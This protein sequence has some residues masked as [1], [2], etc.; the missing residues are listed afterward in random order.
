MN[1]PEGS[2]EKPIEVASDR[3]IVDLLIEHIKNPCKV[4]LAQGKIANI[5]D[6]YIREANRLIPTLNNEDERARIEDVIKKYSGQ[7]SAGNSQNE[8]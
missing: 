8:A 3:E 1:S 6:F 5:R 4:E 7:E 2:G